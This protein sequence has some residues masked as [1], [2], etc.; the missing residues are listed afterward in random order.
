MSKSREV[1][2]KFVEVK[3]GKKCKKKIVRVLEEPVNHLYEKSPLKSQISLATFRKYMKHF[4]IFKNFTQFVSK[5]YYCVWAKNEKP[6]M[7]NILKQ[8]GLEA[9]IDTNKSINLINCKKQEL[10]NK[11]NKNKDNDNEETNSINEKLLEY[12][13]MIQKIETIHAVNEHEKLTK[14]QR[15]ANMYHKKTPAVL[16]NRIIIEVEYKRKIIVGNKIK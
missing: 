11:L 10:I 7:N 3:H 2:T 13:S 16:D 6:I 12:D 9:M 5:C 4:K 1:N 15:E 8:N 14:A